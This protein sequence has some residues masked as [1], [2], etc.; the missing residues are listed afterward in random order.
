MICLL[1]CASVLEFCLVDAVVEF[2][3]FEPD[4]LLSDDWND[5]VATND[6][7]ALPW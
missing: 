4:P 1:D 3:I 6:F 5:I 7:F 2:D